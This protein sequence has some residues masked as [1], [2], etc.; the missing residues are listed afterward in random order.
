MIENPRERLFD[1]EKN[2]EIYLNLNHLL[3]CDY[4]YLICTDLQ[5][6]LDKQLLI[7]NMYYNLTN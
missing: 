6:D 1:Y 5:K 3:T 7:K 4:T 2:P